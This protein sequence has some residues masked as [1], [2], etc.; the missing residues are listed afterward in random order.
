MDAKTGKRPATELAAA[1]APAVPKKARRPP[2]PL[3]VT[4]ASSCSVCC[5]PFNTAQRAPI[6]CPQCPYEACKGC[7]QKYLLSSIA[8]PHCMNCRNRWTYKTLLSLFPQSFVV[9]DFR[10]QRGQYLLDRAKSHIPMVMPYAAIHT[11]LEQV[12]KECNLRRKE[13]RALSH[14]IACHLIPVADRPK[15]RAQYNALNELYY[16]L[17][18]RR[19]ELYDQSYAARRRRKR[20]VPKVV[21]FEEPCPVDDCRGFVDKTTQRCALCQTFVCRKCTQVLGRF[22]PNQM[23][24][25]AGAAGS[26]VAAAAT[27]PSMAQALDDQKTKASADPTPEPLDESVEAPDVE[28]PSTGLSD[29]EK[30]ALREF[31]KVHTCKPE[32]VESVAEIRRHSRACPSCKSRIFRI[33]GCDTMWCTRCNTGFNW[34]TGLVITDAR[35]LHNPHYI[36]FVRNNPNFQYTQQRGGAPENIPIDNPCDRLTLDTIHLPI[37]T[38]VGMQT[39]HLHQALREA[40]QGFQQEMLHVRTYALRKFV[41]GNQYDEQE[42]ALRY[43]TKRWSE[44]RW[45]IMVEHHDRFRQTNQEFSDVLLTW[46]VVMNDLF[47]HFLPPHRVDPLSVDDAE[48]FLRQMRHISEY[49]NRTLSDLCQAY[50]RTVSL[51]RLPPQSE[52]SFLTQLCGK[53]K[54]LFWVATRSTTHS[55]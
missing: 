38:N 16:A 44:T 49:T 15:M 53:L 33:S 6:V 4:K 2:K 55:Q 47:A 20:D 24:L 27:L 54:A 10:R 11:E 26:A 9:K 32:D 3:V 46:L 12:N 29:D 43:V 45:R 7:H 21:Q 37:T 34:R 8:A 48:T 18:Q 36:D 41:R 51:L 42:Y 52:E 19:D 14:A 17:R 5:D 13:C 22:S 23:T 28:E 40:I 25:S 31:K 1:D 30:K 35:D 50:N 39:L